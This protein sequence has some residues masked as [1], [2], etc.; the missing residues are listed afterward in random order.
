[1]G[2]ILLLSDVYPACYA[3]FDIL[4]YDDHSVTDLPLIERKEFLQKVFAFESPRMAISRHIENQG[5]AFYQLAKRQELEGIIPKR[6][7]SK[8][9]VNLF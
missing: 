4:Y 7:D 5:I 6:K 1:M 2:K 9:A 8:Y 3:A